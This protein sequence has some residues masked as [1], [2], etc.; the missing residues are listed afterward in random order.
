MNMLSSI[1]KI[2][3]IVLC[4]AL[5]IGLGR[6]ATQAQLS[7]NGLQQKYKELRRLCQERKQGGY[8]LK[9]VD[10]LIERG[11]AARRRRDSTEAERLMDRA[12]KILS[13]LNDEA[14]L[15]S[16]ALTNLTAKNIPE[17]PFGV[18]FGSVRNYHGQ[19]FMPYVRELGAK[20]TSI[21]F[22]WHKVEP[23]R[24]VYDWSLVDAL[25]NQLEPGDEALVMVFTSSNWG[26]KGVGKGYPPLNYDD[27][28]SFVYNLVKHCGGK[29]KY[30]ERDIEPG[31]PGHWDKKFAADY[32]KA[33][34]CFYKA[35][36]VADPT[37]KVLGIGLAWPFGGIE[38][39]NTNFIDYILENGRDYYDMVDI[40][41]YWD[42]YTIPDRVRWLRERMNRFGYQ[43]PIVC[44]ELGG[45]TPLQFPA[46]FQVAAKRIKELTGTRS[47]TEAWPKI[48]RR[49]HSI[50]AE[51]L[52]FPPAIQMF[53]K[54][55]PRHLE[56]KRDRLNCKDLVQRI[57]MALAAGVEK[58]WYW[59]LHTV[60]HPTCGPHPIF[61]K[62][63]LVD[64]QRGHRFP[65]FYAYNRLIGI[66]EHIET[67]E[68]KTTENRHIKFFKFTKKNGKGGYIVWERRDL[69]A[70]EEEPPSS[71]RLRLQANTVTKK[72][73][74]GEQTVMTVKNGDLTLK[75]TDN[76]IIIEEL[77]NYPK[78]Q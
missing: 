59:C 14:G 11:W 52:T 43:K 55:P 45:P 25:L 5:V 53:F 1:P 9:E 19:V 72:T 18:A 7:D 2:G 49:K 42:L 35:V 4:L 8:D 57:T 28:Y 32:V 47:L 40:H 24:S 10:E 22:Y 31:S 6:S 67:I 3:Y 48:M 44:A 50:Y 21:Y 74:F 66:L 30:W 78:R 76:P 38:P 16:K 39:S 70:G 12:M 61:G 58:V 56:E 63:R 26:A 77:N 33:Q 15:A 68:E 65:A 17:F 36:K 41:L 37:A 27:Y 46:Q 71:F 75:L 23:R 13:M 62:L 20:R 34:A 69:F 54:D 64:L 51:K 60:W 29:V 73:I